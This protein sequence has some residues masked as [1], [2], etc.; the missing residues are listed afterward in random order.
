MILRRRIF[1]R[2]L[3]ILG[4]L[5]LGVAGSA[6]FQSHEY[7]QRA[8]EIEILEGSR[9]LAGRCANLLAWNDRV[10]LKE[11]LNGAVLENRA[12]P[13]AWIT[14]DGKPLMSTFDHGVPGSLRSL[15][16]EA[17]EEWANHEF[18]TANFGRIVEADAPINDSGAFLHLGFAHEIL[19]KPFRDQAMRVALLAL[20]A[21]AIGG[22]VSAWIARVTTREVDAITT[23]FED[24]KTK[25]EQAS[26]AKSRFLANMSHEIR[27][28]MNGILGMTG[29]L[30]ETELDDDQEVLALTAE[31]SANSLLTVL[32]DIL[33]FSKIEAQTLELES[34]D[35]RLMRVVEDA[36]D[37]VAFPAHEKGLALASFVEDDVPDILN[38]DPTRLRQIFVNLLGNAVKFTQEG[39]V[40]LRVRREPSTGKELI[41]HGSVTDT[42]VGIPPEAHDRLFR[43]FSQVDSS[44]TRK[45]GGTGLGLAISRQLVGMMGGEIGFTSEV[46]KG[47]TFWF[48]IVLKP[49]RQRTPAQV[50]GS[51]DIENKRILIVDDNRTN[52]EV[53]RRFLQ[54]WNCRFTEAA[55]AAEAMSAL[56]AAHQSGDIFDVAI[57]DMQ[58]PGTDGETLGRHIKS[59]PAYAALP[60]VM[61]TSISQGGV[62]SRVNE[63]GFAAY[64]T[65]PVKGTMLANCLVRILGKHAQD[66]I[67]TKPSMVLTQARLT[68]ELMTVL[69]VEDNKVNQMIAKRM[70]EKLGFAT[71]IAEDGV[72]ATA[73][74]AKKD[75]SLVMMD[76][77]MPVMDGIEATKLIRSGSAPVRN[78][79]VPIIAMTAHSMAGDRERLLETGMT[80]YISKPIMK[81]E[82]VDVLKRNLLPKKQ[83]SGADSH[84]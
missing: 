50:I 14:V 22:G 46:G 10:G 17:P 3:A 57:I 67:R 11:L 74:L 6:V 64:L 23:M 20:L 7:N 26:L 37:I 63:I 71:E 52:R 42:G 15:H 66:P 21:L 43:S 73:A 9:F 76:V 56:G 38:G 55:N 59:T 32:N 53:L 2:V 25:A 44:M 12:V 29:L 51:G 27:T 1:F 60:M 5:T 35:F 4:F 72:Q 81:Q 8:T 78:P 49:G 41:L 48:T 77:Q 83:T 33:D 61:L 13:F 31:R 68:E 34:I 47:T 39:E 62:L 36:V 54:R 69:V 65:K 82:L 28:P 24:A 19:D 16:H 79:N 40:V 70:L 75:F 45:F 18:E 80:D 30:L 84:F 58:M